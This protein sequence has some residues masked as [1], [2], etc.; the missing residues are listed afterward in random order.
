MDT[1]L[2]PASPPSMES[3]WHQGAEQRDEARPEKPG[4]RERYLVAGK[5]KGA[6]AEQLSLRPTLLWTAV[7]PGGDHLSPGPALPRQQLPSGL[8]PCALLA[9]AHSARAVGER[10]S[11]ERA[12]EH[13]ASLSV[14]LSATNTGKAGG[15]RNTRPVCKE[16]RRALSSEKQ[17]R[18]TPATGMAGHRGHGER[19]LPDP[20]APSSPCPR[21]PPQHRPPDKS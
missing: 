5:P 8:W 19:R 17:R 10:M 21:F 15:S 2:H 16:R 11:D 20:C 13:R 9:G 18:L 7:V 3:P 1:R 4:F 6:V 12:H 14:T